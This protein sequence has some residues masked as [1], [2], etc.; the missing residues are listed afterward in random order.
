MLLLIV[1]LKFVH[2]DKIITF[3]YVEVNFRSL[4]FD[5]NMYKDIYFLDCRS[6]ELV[7]RVCNILD[8]Y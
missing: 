1:P 8:K 4:K 7:I 6:L 5:I 3:V 2:A